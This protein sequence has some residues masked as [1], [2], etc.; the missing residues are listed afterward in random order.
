MGTK[1]HTNIILFVRAFAPINTI[2]FVCALAPMLFLQVLCN[3]T[4]CTDPGHKLTPKSFIPRCNPC[5]FH[6][7][8][9]FLGVWKWDPHLGTPATFH[10]GREKSANKRQRNRPSCSSSLFSQVSSNCW[11]CV[12][13]VFGGLLRLRRAG[14]VFLGILAKR[15]EE[16]AGCVGVE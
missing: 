1:T 15:G 7:K 14:V 5:D 12:S 4:C 16:M 11:Q 8:W 2:V 9:R 6:T 3:K 13:W 10:L